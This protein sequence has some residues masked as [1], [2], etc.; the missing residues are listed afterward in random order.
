M[1][2]L[3]CLLL[4]VLLSVA[5][6]AAPIQASL[7]SDGP[8]K[9]GELRVG[10][11]LQMEPGWHVYWKNAGGPGFPPSLTWKLPAG[12]SADPLQFPV[13]ERI[14]FAGEISYA[15]EHQVLFPV[16]L[17][18]VKGPLQLSAEARW[19]ACKETCIP[20]SASLKLDVTDAAASAPAFASTLLPEAPG[21][22]QLQAWKSGKDRAFLEFKGEA[23][24]K[25]DFF[26]SSSDAPTRPE[27]K[28]TPGKGL[29]IAVPPG[30]ARLQGVLAIVHEGK[31]QGVEVD[32]PLAATPPAGSV[33]PAP[34]A[35]AVPLTLA[36]A[37]PLALLGGLV[38]N[39]MPCV[40]PVLSLKAL[41]LLGKDA[42]QPAW[43]QGWVYTLGVVISVWLIAA[44]IVL[45]GKAGETSGLGWGWQMQSPTFVFGLAALFL[46]IALNLFGVFEFGVSLQKLGSAAEGKKGLSESFWSGAVTTVAATP[47]TAP[48]GASALGYAVTQPPLIAFAIFTCLGLGIALP[49]LLL[50]G[51][52]ASR[53]WLPRPGA[54]MESFK[55]ALGFPMLG[56]LVWFLYILAS[57]LNPDGL[58]VAMAALVG[59]A[60]AAW[61]YGRWGFDPEGSVRRRA[62]VVAT[63][64]GVASLAG[65]VTQVRHPSAQAGAVETGGVGWEP[66]TPEK[67]KQAQAEGR[68]VFIDATAA[69]CLNC[70][71][72]ERTVLNTEPVIEA[73][74]KGKVLALR[75]DWT[76]ADPAITALLHEFGRTGVPF[77]VYYPAH[78]DPIALPDVLTQ[79]AVLD[80]L[81][82]GS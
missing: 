45:V 81:R 80:A 22:F 35:A 40:F 53:R 18:G 13:P 75:A 71:L 46:L 60:L 37:L 6:V 72:Y 36:T 33:S 8:P 49:Y 57:L 59:L 16:Q 26:P 65:A 17:H 41:S 5:A 9:N 56:A 1:K 51:V 69:W 48:I 67:L 25:A 30:A 29:E 52:P 28:W 3:Y 55:Q 79:A 27:P 7:V 24:D 68:S 76:R 23:G 61:V 78:G 32:V 34:T 20:G 19:L 31:R 12:V 70:K 62:L 11:L 54:W 10:L 4:G 50:C 47:C 74:K 58:G 42:E 77:Y 64:L 63:C 38:L 21:N 2:L 44:P 39:L 43:T 82:H 15:Y 66:F 14:P 73:M